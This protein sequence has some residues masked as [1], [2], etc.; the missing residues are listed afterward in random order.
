M[1]V[2]GT[3]VGDKVLTPHVVV[4]LVKHSW[5]TNEC[6]CDVVCGTGEINIVDPLSHV[7]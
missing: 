4:F 1:G 3:R 5:E 6:D 2:V 7:V